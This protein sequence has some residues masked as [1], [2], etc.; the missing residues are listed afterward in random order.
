MKIEAIDEVNK[1]WDSYNKLEKMRKI[2]CS[3]ECR[4]FR[5]NIGFDNWQGY[6]KVSDAIPFYSLD[7]TTEKEFTCRFRTYGPKE[8]SCVVT[9]QHEKLTERVYTATIKDSFTITP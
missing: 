3:F 2:I 9:Y 5:K 6:F 7:K 4:I 8:V 1:L